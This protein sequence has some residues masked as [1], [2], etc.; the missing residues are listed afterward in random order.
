MKAKYES[1]KSFSDTAYETA[2]EYQVQERFAAMMAFTRNWNIN[3]RGADMIAFISDRKADY[4]SLHP[5]M[6]T[7]G[8]TISNQRHFSDFIMSGVWI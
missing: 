6:L 5:E 1:A 3:R 7:S 8:D 4:K 2:V